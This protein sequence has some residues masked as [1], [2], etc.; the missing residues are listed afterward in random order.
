M[1]LP[2][3]GDQGR[4]KCLRTAVRRSRRLS[5]RVG[6][7]MDPEYSESIEFN[8]Q[9]FAITA[10]KEGIKQKMRGTRIGQ[11]FHIQEVP[12]KSSFGN[13]CLA[14][15][16]RAGVGTWTEFRMSFTLLCWRPCHLLLVICPPTLCPS[17]RERGMP[18]RRL[19]LSCHCARSN[20]NPHF[21]NSLMCYPGTLISMVCRKKRIINI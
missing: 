14:E 1:L 8:C 18:L 6:G 19:G 21:W 15:N 4:G 2:P 16:H 5:S 7:H 11:C 20:E 10:W 9:F 12:V 3:S 17:L 13:I